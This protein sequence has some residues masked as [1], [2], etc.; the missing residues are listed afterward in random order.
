MRCIARG[1]LARLHVVRRLTIEAVR[2]WSAE[3]G[4]VRRI[5]LICRR[6]LDIRSR[7]RMLKHGRLWRWLRR[8]H[9][10]EFTRHRLRWH[11][12]VR[13]L[14]LHLVVRLLRLHR[15]VRL[16]R[17]HLVVRL[18]RLHLVVGLLRGHLV[19]LKRRLR[20]L[21]IPGPRV[22][23]LLHRRLG[24][25]WR[26]VLCWWLVLRMID[27]PSRLRKERR[28]F[29]T[30]RGFEFPSGRWWGRLLRLFREEYAT[31]HESNEHESESDAG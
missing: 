30:R 18:W 31:H 12:V 9:L 19:H 5:R 23:M 20:L 29:P 17:L 14:R 7:M 13:L 21:P 10:L 16:L 1:Q 15:L 4:V 22:E 24:L 6:R 25:C 28:V 26:L 3:V 2:R 27:R 8:R 11:L